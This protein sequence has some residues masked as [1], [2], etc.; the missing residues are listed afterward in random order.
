[1]PVPV[2]PGAV[3]VAPAPAPVWTPEASELV[4]VVPGA[5]VVDEAPAPAPP[6]AESELVP[7]VCANAP[8]AGKTASAAAAAMPATSL[9]RDSARIRRSLDCWVL[10]ISFSSSKPSCITRLINF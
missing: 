10:D 5:V 7:D 4:P 6:P 8:T 9:A 3:V 2:V 1:M